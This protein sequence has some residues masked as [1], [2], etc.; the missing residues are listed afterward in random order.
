[1]GYRHF[2]QLCNINPETPISAEELHQ[3]GLKFDR[4]GFVTSNGDVQRMKF[5]TY[6][7]KHHTVY[8]RSI[9]GTNKPA[10][11]SEINCS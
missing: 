11:G 3:M 10:I 9:G 7:V 2:G 5:Q 6:G 4:H 8:R 1:M